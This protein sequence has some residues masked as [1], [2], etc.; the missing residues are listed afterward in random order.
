MVPFVAFQKIGARNVGP[1]RINLGSDDPR[2]EEIRQ[3]HDDAENGEES[4]GKV[5]TGYGF[6]S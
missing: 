2:D 1:S 3:R 4:D 5:F 6:N